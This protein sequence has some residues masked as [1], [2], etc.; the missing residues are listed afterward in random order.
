MIKF[1]FAIL[2][3]LLCSTLAIAQPTKPQITLHHTFTLNNCVPYKLNYEIKKGSDNWSGTI[4]A[5]TKDGKVTTCKLKNVR[6]HWLLRGVYTVTFTDT[7]DAS[8]KT[9]CEGDTSYKYI[10][11]KPPSPDNFY[12]KKIWCDNSN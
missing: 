1:I 10:N 3:C 2:A 4:D 6:V 5:A 7:Q 9:S 12:S 11:I 8:V